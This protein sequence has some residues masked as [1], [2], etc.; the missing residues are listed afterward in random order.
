MG[1]LTEHRGSAYRVADRVYLGPGLSVTAE[2][3]ATANYA[4]AAVEVLALP[5]GADVGWVKSHERDHADLD[6]G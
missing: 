3:V 1:R 5:D 4:G 6:R 2:T